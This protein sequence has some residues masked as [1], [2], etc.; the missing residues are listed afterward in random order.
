MSRS[1]LPALVLTLGCSALSAGCS[2]DATPPPPASASAAPAESPA[3]EETPGLRA[4]GTLW[5]A[6]DDGTLMTPGVVDGIVR[7]STTADAPVADAAQRLAA[8]Y[9]AAMAARGME[10][11]PDAVAAVS[12]AAADM[13]GVCDDSGLISV[14]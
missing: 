9:A 7:A 3:V 2:D 13:T 4:C 6:V 12:A 11:E 1:W 8:A 10:S 14:G 5:T